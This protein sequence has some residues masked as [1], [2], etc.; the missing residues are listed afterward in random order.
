MVLVTA[1]SGR[2]AAR[3]ARA[4]LGLRSFSRRWGAPAVLIG[5]VQAIAYFDPPQHLYSIKILLTHSLAWFAA[6]YLV[7]GIVVTLEH[8]S[9]PRARA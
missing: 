8:H 5:G 1:C 9:E 2:G 3:P 6:L 4:M 7:A